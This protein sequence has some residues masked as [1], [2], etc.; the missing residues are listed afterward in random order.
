MGLGGL[1]VAA[2]WWNNS[3]PELVTEEVG[4]SLNLESYLKTSQVQWKCQSL[5]QAHSWIEPEHL[6]HIIKTQGPAVQDRP[7]KLGARAEN[8]GNWGFVSY[9]NT[10]CNKALA[11][12]SA[13]GSWRSWKL[14]LEP[15]IS[16]FHGET[17]LGL[18]AWTLW[19]GSLWST[20]PAPTPL[21]QLWGQCFYSLLGKLQWNS[22]HIG[23]TEHLQDLGSL[24]FTGNLEM[25]G[26]IL[27]KQ[28]LQIEV[29]RQ[30]PIKDVDTRWH[31]LRILEG[32]GT[33]GMEL[34][35]LTLWECPDK[36]VVCSTSN[37]F[38]VL[39]TVC[40]VCV[41]IHHAANV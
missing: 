25:W 6:Q 34:A 35:I 17:E 33:W 29:I 21:D 31:L 14:H 16:Q 9:G 19:D 22:K 2:T 5:G 1:G 12:G 4:S 38:E 36:H 3:A 27:G 13:S 32:K 41:P 30:E 20:T 24:R 39:Q 23:F 40:G 37:E 26:L 28:W 18:A 10:S 15:G 11:P 8:L 7:T